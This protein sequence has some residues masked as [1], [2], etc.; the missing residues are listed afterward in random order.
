MKNIY[1]WNYSNGTLDHDDMKSSNY[2]SSRESHRGVLHEEVT[3]D[4]KILE[5][6]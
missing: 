2:N 4:N 6:E 5:A 3:Y 1:E